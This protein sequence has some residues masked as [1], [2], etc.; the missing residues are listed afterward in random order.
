MEND[1]IVLLQHIET[2]NGSIHLLTI[3][4]M[5]ERA[6]GKARVVGIV[7]RIQWGNSFWCTFLQ[8][9]VDVLPWYLAQKIHT[10]LLGLELLRF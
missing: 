2:N 3:C 4:D 6:A 9:M 10:A 7:S 8:G 1:V 5:E